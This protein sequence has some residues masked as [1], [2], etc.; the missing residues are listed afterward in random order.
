M[1][2]TCPYKLNKKNMSLA[3]AMEV[4]FVPVESISETKGVAARS[5]LFRNQQTGNSIPT[6]KLTPANALAPST[7]LMNHAAKDEY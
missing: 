4:L 5:G 2:L 1:L 7:G 6:R 3:A